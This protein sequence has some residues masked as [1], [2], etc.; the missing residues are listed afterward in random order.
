M[1][2]YVYPH[3]QSIAGTDLCQLVYILTAMEYSKVK[4]DYNVSFPQDDVAA[5]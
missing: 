2:S 5:S 3:L 1:S 4:P